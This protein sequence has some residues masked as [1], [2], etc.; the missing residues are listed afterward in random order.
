MIFTKVTGVD[1]GDGNTADLI[2]GDYHTAVFLDTED[3][4]LHTSED[5][6]GDLNPATYLMREVCVGQEHHALIVDRGDTHKIVH[7]RNGNGDD[8]RRLYLV[9]GSPH[10]EAQGQEHLAVTLDVDQVFLAGADKDQTVKCR[11]KHTLAMP[12]NQLFLACHGQEILH[13]ILVK[14]TLDTQ[15]TLFASIGDAH[16]EPL[17]FLFGYFC[18]ENNTGGH[19]TTDDSCRGHRRFLQRQSRISLP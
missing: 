17:L 12:V 2:E 7:G 3:S 15:R 11:N 1:V 13:M 16:G 10:E 6:V 4:A 8:M 19:R 18:V 5:T 9:V 14:E